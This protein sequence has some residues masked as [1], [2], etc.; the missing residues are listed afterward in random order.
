VSEQPSV[1]EVRCPDFNPYCDGS[2]LLHGE[3]C[4]NQAWAER[5]IARYDPKRAHPDFR[6]AQELE[7]KF[8]A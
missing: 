6:E 8:N 7:D 3:W 1:E 4:A 5:M 2:D